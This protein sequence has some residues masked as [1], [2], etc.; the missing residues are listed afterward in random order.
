MKLRTK[1]FFIFFTLATV[2][3]FA[4]GK[5]TA[6]FSLSNIRNRDQIAISEEL[7]DDVRDRLDQ[8]YHF[9]DKGSQSFVFLSEDKKTVLKFFKHYRWREPFFAKWLPAKYFEKKREPHL[10]TY[11]SCRYAM[12]HFQN[13][14]G[15]ITLHLGSTKD[16]PK[17]FTIKDRIHRTF[18]IDLNKYD[19]ILQQKAT[20]AAERFISHRQS[21]QI[22]EAKRSLSNLFSLLL[23]RR[24]RGFNDKDP[25]LI[26]NFGFIEEMAVQIDVGGF[27]VDPRKGL[28]YFYGHELDKVQKKILT[29]LDR[30]YPELAP[31][32]IEEIERIRSSRPIGC[33]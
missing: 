22:E 3:H 30:Y 2:S 17:N 28:D 32:A 15:V 18:S 33:H 24:E 27:F 26:K 7:T 5:W 10:D 12:E 11:R 6:H 16:F 4:W 31:Y 9:I 21:G 25:H 1:A 19:F 20:S 29:W 8:S 14:T 13:E 23:L